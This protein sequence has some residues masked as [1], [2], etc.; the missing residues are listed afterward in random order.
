MLP[1]PPRA[2]GAFSAAGTVE[3]DDLELI[4]S[5]DDLPRPVDRVRRR[6]WSLRLQILLAFVGGRILRKGVATLS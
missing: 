5:E 1:P 3:E 4:S 6:L 2:T